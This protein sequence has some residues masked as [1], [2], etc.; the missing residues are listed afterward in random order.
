MEKT[1]LELLRN[2]AEVM[3]RIAKAPGDEPLAQA[4]R[5][6]A[7]QWLLDAPL[8]VLGLPQESSAQTDLPLGGA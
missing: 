8:E 6:S 5:E 2:A 4:L 1:T 3:Q 7:R